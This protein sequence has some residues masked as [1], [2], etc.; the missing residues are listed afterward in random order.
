MVDARNAL[1]GIQGLGFT[2]FQA[3]DVVRHPLVQSIVTAYDA[4]TRTR[5]G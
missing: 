3:G 4:H 5:R 2:I 1:D